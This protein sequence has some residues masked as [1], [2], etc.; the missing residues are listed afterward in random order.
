ML[1]HLRGLLEV[2]RLV[3]SGAEL[4]ELLE[5]IAATA[6]DALG[7]R[8]VSVNLYRRAWDDFEVVTV[9][10]CDDARTALLGRCTPWSRWEPYLAERFDRGGVAFVPEEEVDWAVVAHVPD[11]V[12]RD[13]LDAWLPGDALLAPLRSSDGA[14]LGFISVDEPIAGLRPTDDELETLA[15]LAAHVAG[16]IE[17]AQTLA[18]GRADRVALT[19]LL[20]VSSRLNGL[21]GSIDELLQT[22]ASAIAETLGFGVVAVAIADEQGVFRPRGSVG[23]PAAAPLDCALSRELVEPL[24]QAEFELGGCYVLTREEALARTPAGLHASTRNGRGPHGWNRHWLLVPL[25]DRDGSLRGYVWAD[26]PEDHL[27]PSPERLQVLRTFA[28]Q[29][30]AALDSAV[31]L[32]ALRRRNTELAALNDTTIALLAGLDLDTVLHTICD[33]ARALAGTRHA[34]LYLVDEERQRLDLAVRLGMFERSDGVPLRRGEGLGGVVWESGRSLCVDDYSTWAGRVPLPEWDDLGAVLGVPLRYG[35]EVLGVL[36]LALD[37]SDRTF[38]AAEI[39]QVERFAQLAS[40]ALVNARL[41]D[42]LR[43]TEKLHRSVLDASTDLIA[44]SDLEGRVVYASRSHEATLGYATEDL[45][46]RHFTGI[47]HPDDLEQTAAVFSEAASGAKGQTVPIRLRHRDDRWVHVEGLVSVIRDDASAPELILAVSRDVSER[48]R[49]HDQLRHAQKMESIGRLA[50]GIAHDFNNLLTAISGYAE[51]ARLEL[52]EG[53]EAR[54]HVTEVTRAAGRAAELTAQL[55]AFGRK[56]VLQPRVVDLNEVVGRMATM[57]ARM[58]GADVILST[59]FDDEVGLTLADP[60][61]LEQVVLNLALNARDAM[62]EGGQLLLR[63]RAFELHAGEPAPHPDLA[64]GR[65]ATLLVR[66]SGVGISGELAS[67]IFEPFF[68]TKDVGEGTGLGLA[69]VDGIVSQSGGVVWLES[70]PGA[71]AGFTVC[72]PVVDA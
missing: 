71:G 46:G 15:L 29:A 54:E 66:D 30:N 57:L 26:D 50:G 72:L 36:G 32:D 33:Q 7:Y 14:V 9:Y 19:Q 62:P 69:S 4:P 34:Y 2:S 35:D 16:A 38:A 53:T 28:N 3:R 44:L 24:F 8:T 68:T 67:R 11:L 65:Y 61:Q 6:A 5:A 59:A 1:P 51:L 41:Y 70:E 27:V 13:E 52:D 17:S 40:L 25:R 49:L 37:G 43:R 22:I 18:S 60:A 10:G 56:Q 45:V 63:T 42:A 64:P 31:A 58:L 39:D 48:E 12:P 20:E 55:L 23:W 47:V 21:G